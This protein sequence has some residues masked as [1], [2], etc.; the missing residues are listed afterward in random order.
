MKDV[1]TTEELIAVY[2]HR[3]QDL[4]PDERARVEALLEGDAGVRADADAMHALL[5]DVRA[6][7]EPT[8]PPSLA[9]EIADAVE[10]ASES[11]WT[12][13]RAWLL[14]PAMG[15][16]VAAA[17]A[18]LLGLWIAKR[19]S[20]DDVAIAATTAPTDAALAPAPIA[21]A[22]AA[23][24]PTKLDLF[25]GVPAT[26]GELADLGDLDEHQLDKLSANLDDELGQVNAGPPD[27]ELMPQPD[28]GWVDE[29]SS[30]EV[31]QLDQWLANHKG[32]T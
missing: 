3:P 11:R 20:H 6:L 30:T 4:S 7:P 12:R 27:E 18:G 21:H 2:A 16:G 8:P 25:A 17:T 14:R 15:L 26:S 28:L 19:T 23:P 31:D 29:L 9:G 22:P 5:L 32:P 24:A 10:R 13:L 1:M